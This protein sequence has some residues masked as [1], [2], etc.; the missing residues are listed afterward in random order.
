GAE[1]E[2]VCV[3]DRTIGAGRRSS[4]SRMFLRPAESRPNLTVE[5]NA[6]AHRVIIEGSRAVGVEFAQDGKMRI[7]R[8]GKEVVLSGGT[9]NSPQLLL[10]SGIGP[11]DE[12]RE[13]GIEPV[14]DRP[15]VGKNLHDHVNAFVFFDIATNDS[16]TTTLRADQVALNALRYQL[17]RTGPMANFPSSSLGFIRVMEES[18]RPDVELIIVPIWQEAKV[19][20]PGIRRE[21]HRFSARCAVLH[22]R[23]RGYVKLRSSTPTDK[24]RI[25][26]NIFKDPYDLATLRQGIKAIRTIFDQSPLKEMMAK[27]FMPGTEPGNDADLEEWLRNNCQT[28]QHPA[29]TCRMGAD[30]ASVVDE[31]LR[32]RGIDGLRVADCSVMPDVIG[33]NTNAPT[34]MI[35]EKAAD[36]ILGREPLPQAEF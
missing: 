15:N 17:F 21:P 13:I 32:V 20:F 22:P 12:L 4:T 31:Q 29:G 9:Y 7:A 28:A 35:A 3:P 26:W 24:P 10:L 1:P 18:E 16:L 14:L 8:A 27:E 25:L 6:L 33:G 36:M 2:G 19:W 30:E 34:I 11:A 5:T 23:S